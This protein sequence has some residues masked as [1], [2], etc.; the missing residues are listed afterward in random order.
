MRWR[1]ECVISVARLRRC[2]GVESSRVRDGTRETP[3][4]PGDTD[5]EPAHTADRTR[6][7]GHQHGQG[8]GNTSTGSQ[9]T[10]TMATSDDEPMHLYEVFQ[11]CF[12]KIANK[13][14]GPSS[15]SS[16]THTLPIPLYHRILDTV[17][18]VNHTFRY[19]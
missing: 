8:S 16:H 11:N 15:S 6:D 13:Q 4:T 1:G 9:P 10:T 2:V 14:T 17:T 7:T 19:Q 12:N 3:R 18:I 5:T